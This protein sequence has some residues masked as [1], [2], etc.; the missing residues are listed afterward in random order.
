MRAALVSGNSCSYRQSI[1]GWSRCRT[2][3]VKTPSSVNRLRDGHEPR[4]KRTTPKTPGRAHRTDG[5]GSRRLPLHSLL[6]I[7]IGLQPHP[8]LRRRLQQPCEPRAAVAPRKTS[9][10][11]SKSF[12]ER[13]FRL[14]RLAVTRGATRAANKPAIS[15]TTNETQRGLVISLP[16]SPL[17]KEKAPVNGAFPDFRCNLV[18]IDR[19][20]LPDLGVTLHSGHIGDTSPRGGGMPWKEGHVVDERLRFVARRLDG[21]SRTC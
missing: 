18:A 1:I 21:R 4:L 11:S 13:Q 20:V 17:K 9:N 8:Q 6:Q 2:A 15:A 16:A 12:C 7:P 5:R 10:L 14:E 19:I 3:T